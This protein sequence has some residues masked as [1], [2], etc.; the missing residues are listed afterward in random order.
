MFHLPGRTVFDMGE[1]SE[2]CATGGMHA[3]TQGGGGARDV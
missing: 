3:Q 2:L 1:S